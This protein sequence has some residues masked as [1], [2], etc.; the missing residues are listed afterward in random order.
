MEKW[1]HCVAVSYRYNIAIKNK[2][3]IGS[4][5]YDCVDLKEIGLNIPGSGTCMT[6]SF[7]I[8]GLWTKLETGRTSNP[9]NRSAKKQV[10]FD[11][12]E[13]CTYTTSSMLKWQTLKGSESLQNLCTNWML[14]KESAMLWLFE[15]L[16]VASEVVPAIPAISDQFNF[17]GQYKAIREHNANPS[18]TSD[19]SWSWENFCDNCCWNKKNLK[20]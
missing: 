7:F 5:L 17:S 14:Y 19:R 9:W 2:T 6:R 15:L 10:M 12:M 4:Y 1:L 16:S 20:C 11:R 3:Y 18:D 8:P 13:S